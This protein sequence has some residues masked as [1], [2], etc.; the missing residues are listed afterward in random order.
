MELMIGQRMAELSA[1]CC[2]GIVEAIVGIV[3][4]IGSEH[5]F[6]T[7]FIEAGIVG[8]EWNG[9]YLVAEIIDCLLVC[10]EYISYPFF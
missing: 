9:S 3:H 7:T 2:E 4:L 5:C 10:E 6:Q 8:H 1:G